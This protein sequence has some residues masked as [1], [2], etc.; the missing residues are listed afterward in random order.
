MEVVFIICVI[1]QCVLIMF[2]FFSLKHN[3]K[4]YDGKVRDVDRALR[5]LDTKIKMAE[6]T[7]YKVKI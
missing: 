6:H 5:V 1:I 2:L 4:Q 7:L 3:K